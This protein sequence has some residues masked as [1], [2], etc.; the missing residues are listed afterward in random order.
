[1]SNVTEARIAASPHPVARAFRDLALNIPRYQ[2]PGFRVQLGRSLIALAQLITLTLTSWE[3]LS[4]EVL[5]VTPDTYCAGIKR[6]S[7]FCL[8]SSTPQ[9]YGR[10][11]GIGI[12]LLVLSGLLPRL[13]ALAHLWLALSLN[14]SLSLPDGGE[15][16]A[17]FATTFLVLIELANPRVQGWRR[18]WRGPERSGALRAVSY[19]ASLALCVQLAGIYFESGLAKLAVPEW[20]NGSALFYITRDPLFGPVGWTGSMLHTITMLPEGT[21]ALTW[22]TIVL[23]CAI[24][25]L[26]LLPAR[27]GRYAVAGVIVL[28]LGIALAMGLWTF[29]ATMIGTVLVAAYTLTPARTPTRTPENQEP[30]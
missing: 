21:A 3:N 12:A 16:V 24:A 20:V 27:F 26:L 4:T 7:M 23:E 9:E 5:S 1:M 6:A 10:W 28:H 13:T 19:A 30:A 18:T 14:L 15:S 22:G 11:I 17:V 25:V 2:A 29:S 8:G